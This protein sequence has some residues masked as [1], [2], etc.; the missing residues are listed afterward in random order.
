MV[1]FVTLRRRWPSA[2]SVARLA[3]G[4]LIGSVTTALAQTAEDLY[5]HY[6]GP[7]KSRAI[8]VFYAECSYPGGKAAVIV[9]VGSA[10]GRFVG[11]AWGARGDR[12]NPA[13]ANQGEFT[14]APRVELEDLMVGG[15]GAYAFTTE[16]VES[17]M[18]TPFTFVL[19]KDLHSIIGSDP[20]K[21]C[22]PS[23]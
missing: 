5:V 10:K 3:V 23:P 6:L 17:L 19:P 14:V 16:I 9:P 15:P 12:A 22:E 1:A 18:Q 7:L 8:P 4:L 21:P 2:A 13:L 20:K 11:L